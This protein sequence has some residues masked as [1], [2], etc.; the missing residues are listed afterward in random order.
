MLVLPLLLLSLRKTP[1][2]YVDKFRENPQF[3]VVVFT[4]FNN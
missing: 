3:F 1:R 2:K 4:S